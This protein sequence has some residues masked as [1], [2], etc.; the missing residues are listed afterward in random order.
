ML[1]PEIAQGAAGELDQLRNACFEAVRRVHATRPEVVVIVGA[2][3][4]R[5]FPPSSHGDFRAYGV[6]GVRV[7][8]GKVDD[9]VPDDLPLPMLLGG[10]L[11]SRPE[12]DEGPGDTPLR[13]GHTVDPGAA[14]AECAA[15]GRSL[16][17]SEAPTGLLVM[18][19]GSARRGER[20][21]GYFHPDAEEFDT[22]VS[23]ALGSADVASLVGVAPELAD[24][25]MVSGRA[26]WQVLA[27]AAERSGSWT[28]ELL[29]AGAPYGVG[30][31][32]AS[33]VAAAPGG[34]AKPGAG[35]AGADGAAG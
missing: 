30:Y 32:V 19:D 28:S 33:W 23:A 17:D 25:L 24:D 8:L 12:A 3:A 26:P 5:L 10:W 7:G 22:A 27:G 31:F 18:G 16:A 11:L 14:Q 9:S 21:P 34:G 29:Y 1:L 15:L 4:P 35:A 13:I 2:G 20:A 6:P